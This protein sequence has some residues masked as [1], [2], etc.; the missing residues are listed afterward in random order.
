MINITREQFHAFVNKEEHNPGAI[1]S[2]TL[3]YLTYFDQY[4]LTEKNIS[5]NW[6]AFAP[7]LWWFYRKMYAYGF[8]A[9]FVTSLLEIL[10]LYVLG[11]WGVLVSWL[12]LCILA[13]LYGD[14]LYLRH[15]SKKI[16]KGINTSG[17][18]S[19]AVGLIALL[20]LGAGIG[21]QSGKLSD[22]DIIKSLTQTTKGLAIKTDD[23]I[24]S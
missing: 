20:I 14:Y 9:L 4:K 15:A 24:S 3:H 22:E 2:A 6:S 18:N 21:D 12:C 7:V 8:L 13:G 5:W 1:T 19:W 17:V 16:A 11:P 23:P 10:L